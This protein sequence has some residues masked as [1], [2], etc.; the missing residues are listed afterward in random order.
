MI[1]HEKMGFAESADFSSSLRRRWKAIS[2]LLGCDTSAVIFKK[3]GR[4]LPHELLRAFQDGSSGLAL[5]SPIRELFGGGIFQ[6]P[7]EEFDLRDVGRGN[8]EFIH[9]EAQKE[10][11][12]REI[13]GHFP[14]DARPD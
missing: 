7:N 8:T 1:S 6:T 11:N 4:H 2:R 9:A 5:Q 13:I 3:A 12:H 14:A 10:R